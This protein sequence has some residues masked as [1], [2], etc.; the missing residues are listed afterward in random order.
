ML[1][2]SQ[3]LDF[4]NEISVDVHQFRLESQALRGTTEPGSPPASVSEDSPRPRHLSLRESLNWHFDVVEPEAV[5]SSL[6]PKTAEP[7]LLSPARSPFATPEVV[8]AVIHDSVP[9]PIVPA[10]GSVTVDFVADVR[11][12]CFVEAKCPLQPVGLR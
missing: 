5:N 10:M 4:I 3:L 1:L 2:E 6:E 9:P 8:V 7:Q 12:E 11:R